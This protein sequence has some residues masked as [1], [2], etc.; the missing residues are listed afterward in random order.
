[1]TAVIA[2]PLFLLAAVLLGRVAFI[3]FAARVEVD[4]RP[5][6]C[7]RCHL[8]FNDDRMRGLHVAGQHVDTYEG[9]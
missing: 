8:T 9:S 1:V 6:R 2:T 3:R 4:P 7:A 5:F